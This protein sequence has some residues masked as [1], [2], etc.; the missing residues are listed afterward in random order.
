MKPV[1]IIIPV[2]KSILTEYESISFKQYRKILGNYPTYVISP[3]GLKLPK[4]LGGISNLKREYFDSYYFSGIP[5]YN[6]LMLSSAFYERFSSY[7]FMLIY[8]LDAFVFRD[9]LAKWCDANYDYIG[10]PWFKNYGE[11]SSAIDLFAVG[12]GGLSLRKIETFIKT[13]KCQTKFEILRDV[14]WDLRHFK[15]IKKY[16]IGTKLATASERYLIKYTANEDVFWS[17]IAKNYAKNFSVASIEV[18]LQFSFENSPETLFG[19]NKGLPFA[20]HKW[21]NYIP[22]WKKHI[23]D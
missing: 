12:N 5:G 17:L 23:L 20:C 8:Q 22:F 4:E 10:A 2:Y 16:F 19:I 7:K 1:C 15:S 18:A 9:D 3:K 21:E 6:S 13:I 11:G 14:F